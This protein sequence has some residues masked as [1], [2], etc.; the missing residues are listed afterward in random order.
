MTITA[1]VLAAANRARPT[2]ASGTRNAPHSRARRV[3][4]STQRP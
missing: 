4:G 2:R 3:G 1:S